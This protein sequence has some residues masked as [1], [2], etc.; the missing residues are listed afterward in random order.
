MN[1]DRLM[2][3][4][5]PRGTPKEVVA[6]GIRA[7]QEFLSD[8]GFDPAHF[9]IEFRCR[10]GPWGRDLYAPIV[11][12]LPDAPGDVKERWSSRNWMK[13]QRLVDGPSN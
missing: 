13:E 3:V 1:V 5:V 8:A 11:F 9:R 6:K 12:V 7:S 2:H 10:V 4:T